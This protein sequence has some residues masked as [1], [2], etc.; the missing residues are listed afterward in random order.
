MN[1]YST[2]PEYS[3]EPQLEEMH[4]SI[5]QSSNSSSTSLVEVVADLQEYLVRLDLVI[6]SLG[7]TREGLQ[8]LQESLQEAE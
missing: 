3:V 7:K 5:V 4:H 6:V 1:Q 8:Y 2:E